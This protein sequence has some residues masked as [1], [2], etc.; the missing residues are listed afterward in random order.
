M[1]E[2]THATSAATPGQHCTVFD[3]EADETGIVAV[4]ILHLSVPHNF[5]QR[6][7]WEPLVCRGVGTS[8]ALY[9]SCS[10]ADSGIKPRVRKYQSGGTIKPPSPPC[11]SAILSAWILRTSA[12]MQSDCN[13]Y[14]GDIR[15]PAL[16]RRG[17]GIIWSGLQS[18]MRNFCE[19]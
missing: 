16:W 3:C 6:C 15:S 4:C 19:R 17:A 18:R 13:G 8:P 14:S 7:G 10:L 2:S 9:A 11:N 12:V 5:W 1:I